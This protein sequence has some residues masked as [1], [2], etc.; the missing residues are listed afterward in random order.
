MNALFSNRYDSHARQDEI[1]DELAALGIKDFSKNTISDKD[2]LSNLFDWVAT[3]T[4][5]ALLANKRG[6]MQ[7]CF[8]KGGHQWN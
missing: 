5:I 3:L 4:P 1:C 8:L 6:P 2:M 7:D